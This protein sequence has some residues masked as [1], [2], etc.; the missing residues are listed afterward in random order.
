MTG[1]LVLLGARG[2]NRTPTVIL[3]A[4]TFVRISGV[5][6]CLAQR[7]IPIG[8]AYAIWTGIGAAGTFLTAVLLYNDPTSVMRFA[9]VALI[10]ADV[11]TIKLA[12]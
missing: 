1:P 6:L 2:C 4:V 3:V 7:T 9:G 8:T 5:L 12:H 10:I 11:V